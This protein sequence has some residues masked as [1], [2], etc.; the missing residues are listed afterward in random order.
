MATQSNNEVLR[1]IGYWKQFY[2]NTKREA[3]LLSMVIHEKGWTEDSRVTY[4]EINS[5]MTLRGNK[6]LHD[7][8]KCLNNTRREVK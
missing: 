2:A 3:M 5:T 7:T 1:T 6:C 4:D 8:D